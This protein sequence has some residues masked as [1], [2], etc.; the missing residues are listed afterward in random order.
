[1]VYIWTQSHKATK[2]P[3]DGKSFQRL[4]VN[5]MIGCVLY[6]PHRVLIFEHL[7][8]VVHKLTNNYMLLLPHVAL[9]WLLNWP[10]MIV[11]CWIVKFDFD[12]YGVFIVLKSCFRNIRKIICKCLLPSFR[13]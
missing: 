9:N 2:C 5:S 1:M 13:F 11:L 6:N 4:N 8:L 3:R 12:G 10:N 7:T